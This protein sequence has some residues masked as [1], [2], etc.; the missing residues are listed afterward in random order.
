L[1]SVIAALTTQLQQLAVTNEW[2]AQKIMQL[3]STQSSMQ[4]TIKEIQDTPAA[5]PVVVEVP[6]EPTPDAALADALATLATRMEEL[7]QN[8]QQQVAEQ[9][10]Q[11]MQQIGELRNEATDSL[12]EK[13]KQTEEAI[14]AQLEQFEKRFEY[15]SRVKMEVKELVRKV[16]RQEQSLEDI[17]VGIE[18]LAKSLGSDDVESETSE[19][20][21]EFIEEE[22]ID[23]PLPQPVV[24]K[25]ALHFVP[26]VTEEAQVDT[27]VEDVVVEANTPEVVS[28]PVPIDNSDITP[29]IA[30]RR[31]RSIHLSKMSLLKR[32]LR[33]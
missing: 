22:S 9:M 31:L 23:E 24:R 10:Q 13:T 12:E 14:Q 7:Q 20:G 28:K 32:I 17:R 5:V 2:Q 27:V 15:L 4:F 33:K 26:V 25:T 6:S 19:E 11:N 29:V 3:E 8:V 16:D 1:T 18:V 21:N 30:S